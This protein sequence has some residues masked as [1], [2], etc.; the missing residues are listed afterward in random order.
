MICLRAPANKKQAEQ[1]WAPELDCSPGWQSGPQPL[2]GAVIILPEWT[3]VL[4]LPQLHEGV[5][6]SL[7]HG[8]GKSKGQRGTPGAVRGT[9]RKH[10]WW[11]GPAR[12]SLW[13]GPLSWTAPP[14][15]PWRGTALCS[16]W[17]FW[18]SW[19]SGGACWQHLADP[20]GPVSCELALPLAAHTMP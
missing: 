13:T 12:P 1:S 19:G 7:P 15:R 17:L 8:L 2:P 10:S 16:R 20:L 5:L 4:V 9:G 3:R 14:L 18:F 11:M 6:P